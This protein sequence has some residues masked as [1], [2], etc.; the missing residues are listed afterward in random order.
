MKKSTLFISSLMLASGLNAQIFQDNF[1]SYTSGSYLGPQSAD[2]TTWSGTEGTA[3]DAMVSTSQASSAPNS[4]YI[5]GTSASGGAT[6]LVLPFDQQYTDGI[7]TYEMKMF[8]PTGKSA[9]FNFQASPTIGTTWA[10]NF[11][12]SAGSF[13]IDDGLTA[14]L[15]TGA[16][17]MNQWFTL[18]IEANLVLGSWEV[19]V[20][21]ASEGQWANGI[22]ELASIDLFPI[23][24]SYEFYFDDVMY[25]HEDFVLPNLNAA[26]SGIVMN[27]NIAGTE[28]NPVVTITNAGLT[29]ID[30]AIVTIV[31]D[32]QTYSKFLYGIGLASLASYEVQF[33]S[34]PLT[35]GLKDVEVYVTNVNE[36][37]GDDDHTDDILITDVDP[38]V[39]AVGKMVVGEEGTGTWC[40]WC[41][42]GTVWM[43]RY[44]NQFGDLW[45]GIAVHN[46]DPMADVT[47]D[48]GMGSLI[49]GYPSSLVDRG[50]EVDPAG[51]SSDFYERLQIAPTAFISTAET[52]NPTTRE[53]SVEVTA[54]FQA[55]A[56]NNYRLA[57]VLTE[58]HVKG[59]T[60]GYSQANYYSGGGAGDLI[61]DDGVNWATLPG[62]VPAANMEY[63]HV[64]RAILPSFAGDN[65][66]FPA[67]VNAGESY[68]KTFTYTLPAEWAEWNMHVIGM[69]IDP[70]G[71]IDNAGKAY[72][73]NSVGLTEKEAESSFIVYPNPATSQATILLDIVNEADV[74]I[75]LIDLSGKVVNARNYKSVTGVNQINMN[76]NQLNSGVYLL[77]VTIN[78]QT[79]TERLIIQ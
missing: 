10:M 64:A 67:T 58:D 24:T 34:V 69:L 29:V 54:D 76:T 65:T 2:W 42:R 43:D 15:A 6:D 12:A 63:N 1:D 59:T 30:D 73:Q 40:G 28:V 75:E 68:S 61:G 56:N 41:P 32:G 38:V 21:G 78:G 14:D 33:Y 23:N 3:E 77:N 45:A 53:L 79:T 5:K 72:L 44:E 18:R 19:F 62:T 36:L 52:W 7:F 31:Y 70:S 50:V 27:G 57:L 49:S 66:V 9:Y 55:E 35:A 37:A 22:N 74:T 17:P 4:V 46:G 48:S 26:V 8:I 25:D 60:S 39:P 51:M 20:D 11:D 47:Y 13:T 16:V 71:R